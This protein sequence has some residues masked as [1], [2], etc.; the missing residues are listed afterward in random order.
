MKL[1]SLSQELLFL[2]S[3]RYCNQT[4]PQFWFER[5]SL[6]S[7]HLKSQLLKNES[8]NFAGTNENMKDAEELFG[9]MISWL[10]S[11]PDQICFWLMLRWSL[12]VCLA[13]LS[14]ICRD[15]IAVLG[16]QMLC[17]KYTTHLQ[18]YTITLPSISFFLKK[19]VPSIFQLQDKLTTHFIAFRNEGLYFYLNT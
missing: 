4:L 11:N 13:Y 10:T 19:L 18:S 5:L 1:F 15:F 16:F 3:C 12:N 17:N 8:L 7:Y 6:Q 14:K 2:A 9:L